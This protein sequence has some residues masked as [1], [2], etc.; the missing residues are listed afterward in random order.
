MGTQS[1]D[2]T[3]TWDGVFF[4]KDVEEAGPATPFFASIRETAGLFSGSV[5]EPH[6]VTK[7]TITA[8][9][10]GNRRE[11][12]VAFAKDYDDPDELYLET[13]QYSGVLSADGEIITGEWRIGHWAGRFEMTRS[14]S[15]MAEAE[16]EEVVQAEL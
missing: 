16:Q 15:V 9:I 2:L 12:S 11:H 14:L 6:E 10:M 8:T 7:A 3:G 13:V 1:F 4:Y 5:I